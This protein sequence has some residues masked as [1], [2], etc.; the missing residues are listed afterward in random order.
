MTLLVQISDPHFGTEQAPVVEA[1]VRF[2]HA[3]SPAVAMLSGDITQRARRSQFD[4]ARAFIDRLEVP[5]T[6]VIPGNHDIPLYNLAARV[7][8][9]YAG[10]QRAFGDDLE[11][12]FETDDML[13]LTLNTTRPY[14]HEAGA[15]SRGQ[16]ER[17]ARRLERAAASQLR[18]VVTHQPVSVTRSEDRADLLHGHARAVRRWAA[19]GADLILGGHIHLPFVQALQGARPGSRHTVWAVQAGTAVSS[20]VRSDAGNSVNLIRCDGPAIPRRCS[21]ERWDYDVAADRF[22]L[23]ARN[24]LV[25]DDTPH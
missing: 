9:P 20:R 2:V 13:I 19:A 15:V 16:I 12:A 17:V 4:A 18:I 10:F 24:A 22:G 3:Q 23:V 6:L 7:A 1:L 5:T 14:L 25:F 21:V 8:R 11:P